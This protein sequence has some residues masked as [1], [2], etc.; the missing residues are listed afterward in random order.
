MK[1]QYVRL[2]SMV[3]T[4]L[5][6]LS[7]PIVSAHFSSID[8]AENKKAELSVGYNYKKIGEARIEHCATSIDYKFSSDFKFRFIPCISRVNSNGSESTGG[9]IHSGLTFSKETSLVKF[10]VRPEIGLARTKHISGDISDSS[11]S[12][13]LK[14]PI[15]ISLNGDWGIVKLKPFAGLALSRNLIFGEDDDNDLLIEAG[16]EF[17][18]D[19]NTGINLTYQRSTNNNSNYYSINFILH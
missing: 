7:N 9:S 5:V 4:M 19:E 13:P 10:F 17:R 14:I 15:G 6:G 11:S 8:T 3:L 18:Y 1:T 16:L 2:L 12:A